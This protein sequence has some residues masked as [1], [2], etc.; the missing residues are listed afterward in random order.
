[1]DTEILSYNNDTIRKIDSIEFG[2]FGNEEILKNSVVNQ[3]S[4][5][6]NMPDLYD[7]NEP[8]KNGLLDPRLGSYTH[9]HDCATCGLNNVY[10]VGHF[11]HIAL[12]EPIFHIG[13]LKKYL[14]K[15]LGCICIRC[16]KL[17]VYRN[18][19]EIEEMLK[20]KTGP[21]RLNEIR[22]AVKNVKYCQKPNYGCGA[23]VSKLKLET[24]PNGGVN[25][26]SEINLENLTTEE[27]GVVT[28]FEGKKKNKQVLTPELVYEI[29][30][31]ISDTDCMIMGFDPKKCRPEMMVHKI[32]AVPPVQIRP[33]VRADFT[34][35]NTMENDLTHK[36]TDIVK[37][38]LY[39]VRQKE[40]DNSSRY[41]Q[42]HLNVLQNHI[43]IYFDSEQNIAL[44]EQK[45]RPLKTLSSRLKGKAGRI[46]NE[47]MG[48]RV[49]FSGRTVISSDPTISINQLGLPVKM[50]M[51]L[52]F[53]EIV[54]PENIDELR[55]A[56][57]NGRD[58]YPGANYVFPASTL[59]QGQKALPIDLRYQIPELRY[60]DIV[61]RHLRND[62][63]VLLNRQPTLHKQSMMGHR[64][65]IIDDP[66]LLSLR[67]SVAITSPYGADFRFPS[68]SATGSCPKGW[69][70][71]FWDQQC[72]SALA[73]VYNY[74]VACLLI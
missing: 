52:T 43:S 42:D 68:K 26:I 17:L 3:E 66:S 23:P 29:L 55:K 25:L 27:G 57:K 15:I 20:T 50:A 32:F 46:R 41:G 11:G 6:I 30:K 38:N 62:D 61:E 49:D 10:C 19:E 67:L 36:L 60:G 2:I 35:S 13:Y 33:S 64:V 63:I 37:A 74:L 5:G 59:V 51:N 24:R 47:L 54:T 40:G 45:G 4:E 44:G 9:D 12:S 39:L 72:K 48:K 58:I 56:V 22:N 7:N 28:E 21:E 18:E 69:W 8:K 16:S 53:P 65:K 14:L 1:M 31:N 71:S 73:T 70:K 34:A